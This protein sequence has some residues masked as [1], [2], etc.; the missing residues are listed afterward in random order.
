MLNLQ[1]NFEN[2]YNKIRSLNYK[3]RSETNEKNF[4]GYKNNLT[5]YFGEISLICEEIHYCM[6]G[7]RDIS[8]GANSLFA[9][10]PMMYDSIKNATDFNS[11]SSICDSILGLF[12]A[13]FTETV[14]LKLNSNLNTYDYRNSVSS[15]Y[16]DP[17]KYSDLKLELA[18]SLAEALKIKRNREREVTVLSTICGINENEFDATLNN[19]CNYHLHFYGVNQLD[20]VYSEYKRDMYDKLIYGGINNS[21]ISNDAFDIVYCVPQPVLEREYKN[22]LLVKSEREYINKCTSYVRPGGIMLLSLPYFRLSPEI[23]ETI[24][25]NYDNVQIIYNYDTF[26]NLHS[27]VNYNVYIIGNKK[28]KPTSMGTTGFDIETYK[29]LRLF[30]LETDRG[31][32]ANADVFNIEEIVLPDSVSEIRTFRGS[33]LDANEAEEYFARSISAAAFWKDQS[34]NRTVEDKARPLLPFSVGQLGLVLTSGCLDG[35]IDEGYGYKHVVKGRV[36]KK[37]DTEEIPYAGSY[38]ENTGRGRS[39]VVD[40]IRNRVEINAFLPDGTYKCLA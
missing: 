27:H 5:Y 13:A 15:Y 39:L 30:H 18:Q 29:K 8:S 16:E 40:T 25:R 24:V 7:C 1:Y 23:C 36:I 3:I 17:E 28:D 31:E 32:L 9:I 21:I 6:D 35:I 14:P 37:T 19:Y 20:N 2:V 12:A 38:N 33:V 11:L 4:E 34:Y 10:K 26:S 22:N